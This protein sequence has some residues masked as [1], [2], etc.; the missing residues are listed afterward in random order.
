MATL[1]ALALDGETYLVR[2]V[3]LLDYGRSIE[4][5]VLQVVKAILEPFVVEANTGIVVG[6]SAES[7]Q[8]RT[9]ACFN[10]RIAIIG[11]RVDST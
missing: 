1:A 3:S 5:L 9:I 4:C 2:A 7:I 6:R 10:N 8:L 11:E